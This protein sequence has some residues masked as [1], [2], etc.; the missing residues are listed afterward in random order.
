MSRFAFRVVALAACVLAL[1]AWARE[2]VPPGTWLSTATATRAP[3]T[4]KQVLE[5]A[6]ARSVVLLGEVHDRADHHRWQLH[7][8]SSLRALRGDI[9]IGFEMF[10]RRSQPALDRWTA[11]EATESQFLQQSDWTRVWGFETAL[12]LPLFHFARMH[13][14]PMVALNVERALI[15]E[16]GRVGADAVPES[17]R[18]GVGQ[19]APPPPEYV[20][21]LHEIYVEHGDAK[22]HAAPDDPAFARFVQSQTLWDRAMAEAIRDAQR[23]HPGRQVV[24]LMGRGHTVPGGVPHQLRALGIDDAMVLLPWERDADCAK[25]QP[26]IADAVFGVDAH[27]PVQ[28][29]AERP[30]LGVTLSIAEGTGVRIDQ[31]SDASVASQ[32]GLEAG[33]VIVMIAGRKAVTTGDVA[34]AV[35]RQAP[36]TWLP[37]RVRRNGRDVEIVARFP[38]SAP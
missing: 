26:G 2:C 35:A 14:V 5:Q 9:V 17:T 30:R 32:A 15:R 18:E 33:D 10:P 28:S 21:Y 24:A 38:P 29:A 6:A 22:K 19:P 7:M 3:L 4:E 37:L 34:G 31:V 36:G 13:R 20:A 8:L 12:Y 11:G 25:L 23:R 27:R 1:P 16:V